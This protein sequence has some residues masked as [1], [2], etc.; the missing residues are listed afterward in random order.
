[1]CFS[2]IAMVTDYD[3]WRQS[4]EDVTLEMVLKVMKRNSAAI[5]KVLPE[6]V[7]DLAE[8]GHCT[9]QDAAR[10]ALV[11]RPAL[12][13]PETRQKLSLFYDKYWK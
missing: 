9:C 7:G 8:R 2:L 13:P 12:I 3:C 1:M 10:D 4:K 11:T 5:K 6:I